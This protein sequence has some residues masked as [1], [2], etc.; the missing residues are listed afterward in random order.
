MKDFYLIDSLN[1]AELNKSKKAFLDN[2]LRIYHNSS[3]VVDKATA[4]NTVIQNRNLKG[5]QDEYNTWLLDFLTE[6]LKKSATKKE[7]QS[8][9]KILG[10][11]Y[12]E[13]SV[14]HHQKGE[15]SQALSNAHQALKIR[16]K[17]ND[18]EDLLKTYHNISMFHQQ[19]GNIS[20][21]LEIYD[22]SAELMRY[23]KDK[24]VLAVYYINMS[25]TQHLQS[26]Y[27]KALEYNYKALKIF[28]EKKNER[29][30]AGTYGNIGFLLS[31][32]G[33]LDA[34]LKYFFKG[35]K[36][37]QKIGY[38]FVESS[39]YAKIGNIYKKKKE[40]KTA[41][42]YYGKALQ[43]QKRRD[44]KERLADTYLQIGSLYENQNQPELALEYYCRSLQLHEKIGKKENMSRALS[45]VGL[46]EIKTGNINKG[47]QQI[48]R[49]FL[50]AQELNSPDLIKESAAAKV[51]LAII[52]GDYKLAY[53]ME[54]LRNEMKAKVEDENT[55]KD[56]IK[57]QFKYEHDKELLKKDLQIEFEKKNARL[58]QKQSD[59]LASKNEELASKNKI[60]NEQITEMNFLIRKLKESNESL[61]QFAAVA[62]HDLKAPLRNIQGFS[63]LLYKKYATKFVEKDMELFMFIIKACTSLNELIDGL[64]N[65]SKISNMQYKSECIDLSEIVSDVQ[66]NLTNTIQ[67]TKIALHISNNLPKVVGQ[68]SLLFQVFLNFINNAIKFRKTDEGLQSTIWINSEYSDDDHVKI[69]IKDNGIGID[70]KHQ[71]E[72]FG[73]FKK[74]HSSSQYEGNGIGLSVCKKIIE[75]FG[76]EIW[77][78]SEKGVGTT[79]FFTL[80]VYKNPTTRLVRNSD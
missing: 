34:A 10:N 26:N 78:E 52:K 11:C 28:E 74:L 75:R 63:Q 68:K 24:T 39:L 22:E 30:I 60:I 5:I 48:E 59:L 40:N 16:K 23:I 14:M 53:E 33:E 54:K 3:F 12:H 79:F 46:L 76:G 38:E 31:E 51:N 58:I 62:A 36:F 77:L 4:I 42:E 13:R 9:K 80:K 45:K 47:N 29:E 43:I 25:C 1:V 69:S 73:I 70:K 55:Q 19:L 49:A 21:A 65:Y 56:L 66:N 37:S 35:L 20:K 15:Y 8:L 18:K 44:Q 61:N 50:L 7:T 72:V 71:N 67:K 6:H 57:Q 32:Q 2:Q 41:L 17:L 27:S 64:L